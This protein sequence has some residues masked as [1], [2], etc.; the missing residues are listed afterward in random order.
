[1]LFSTLALI[2]ALLA[3]VSAEQPRPRVTRVVVQEQVTIRIPVVRARPII[4][5]RWIERKG[6]GCIASRDVLAAT[7]R[8]GRTVD[9][10]LRGRR[11]VRAQMDGD[12]PALDFYGGFYLQPDDGRICAD[13]DEI[14]DRVGGSCPIERFRLMVPR[15]LK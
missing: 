4:P 10:H 8:D 12:C 13:R 2:P 7:L 15:R 6:P 11:R 9:F 3:L 14:R 1:L 5:V